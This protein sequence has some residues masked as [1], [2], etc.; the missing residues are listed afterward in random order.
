MKPLENETLFTLGACA[1]WMDISIPTLS[2][3]IRELHLPC[4]LVGRTW[5]FNKRRINEWS[6]D[7]CKFVYDGETDPAEISD[8]N[9]LVK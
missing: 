2:K 8:E 1:D 3:Y 4:V 7:H 6:Y 9:T 5:I